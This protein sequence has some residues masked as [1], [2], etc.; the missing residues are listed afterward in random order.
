MSPPLNVSCFAEIVTGMKFTNDCKY[1]ISVSGDRW[2]IV[3]LFKKKKIM[4]LIKN[5]VV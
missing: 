2:E 1:L 4:N 5:T 3:L